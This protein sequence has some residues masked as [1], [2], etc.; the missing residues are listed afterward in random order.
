[1][2]HLFEP[3]SS[4]LLQPLEIKNDEP[5]DSAVSMEQSEVS[6]HCT[7]SYEPRPI[8][9]FED[10][11]RQF[12]AEPALSTDWLEIVH[13]VEDIHDAWQDPSLSL[14]DGIAAA[15]S[16]KSCGGAQGQLG[17]SAVKLDEDGHEMSR[18]P[19]TNDDKPIAQSH[20]SCTLSTTDILTAFVDSL[21][22]ILR[23]SLLAV[24]VYKLF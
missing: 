12:C 20:E 9:I 17:D 4:A 19:D 21:P 6:E 18:Q 3:H 23:I 16:Q 24:V 5:R 13:Q 1:M 10:Q 7:H 11:T 22:I 14:Y 2:K 8:I 15:L